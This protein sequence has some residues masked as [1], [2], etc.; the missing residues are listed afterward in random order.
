M[1]AVRA[2]TFR[3][4]RAQAKS[5]PELAWWVFMRLSG[6]VLVILTLFHLFKNYIIV[7]EADWY[8]EAVASSYGDWWNKLYLMALL[9]LG[10]MH[11]AN[12]FRYIIDDATA[13][14]P[15]A[16]FWLK[17]LT[18]SIIGVVF[19][20]GFLALIIPVPVPG[21]GCNDLNAPDPALAERGIPNC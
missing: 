3:D 15:R 8:Y 5:N 16:R 14:N 9:G 4:A 17:S 13:K 12:G 10:L 19:V 21:V 6:T 1:M 20:F 11:G 18:Y 2:R 7:D